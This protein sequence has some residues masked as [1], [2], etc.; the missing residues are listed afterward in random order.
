MEIFHI[1]MTKNR[2]SPQGLFIN[3]RTFFAS[4]ILQKIFHK[5]QQDLHVR[6]LVLTRQVFVINAVPFY[7]LSKLALTQ[8]EEQK[9][10]IKFNSRFHDLPWRQIH[11]ARWRYNGEP[12]GEEREASKRKTFSISFPTWTSPRVLLTENIL[13]IW[14]RFTWQQHAN[15][16]KFSLLPLHKFSHLGEQRQH[17]ER[18]KTLFKYI[19]KH[20]HSLRNGSQKS[21]FMNSYFVLFVC[22][23]CFNN[24]LL[25]LKLLKLILKM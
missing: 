4:S 25:R 18:K 16:K 3:H 17:K 6:L 19:W 12:K 22:N 8:R 14:I 9:N 24:N 7:K 5:L 13:S 2:F 1:F 15:W 23:A 10:Q 11:E 21:I 20:F